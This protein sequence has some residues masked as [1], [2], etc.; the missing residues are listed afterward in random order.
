M[1]VV[2]AIKER[3]S[4]RNFSSEPVSDEEVTAIV[5]AA[6]QAPSPLNSQPWKFFAV[7]NE[8]FRRNV[9]EEGLRYKKVLLEKTG[10]G[11]LEKYDLE[12]LKNVPVMIAIAG[13]PK[14]S[15]ADAFMEESAGA[16]RDACAA[17]A[18]NLLLAAKARGLSTLW[19]TMFDKKKVSGMLG[20]EGPEVPLFL[21]FVGKAA[22][23]TPIMPKKSVEQV[24]Q[25]V[26]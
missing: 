18:Q 23:D 2:S 4:C 15:G 1:D 10:W 19:F 26:R 12:F 9:Y 24:L 13:N 16:W 21:V 14:R 20:I 8:D 22:G 6:A 11:W 5:E 3:H 25:F 17:A 7:T